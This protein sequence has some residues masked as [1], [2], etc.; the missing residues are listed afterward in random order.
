M[1]CYKFGYMDF[2]T[3][4]AGIVMVKHFLRSFLILVCC[5]TVC[6]SSVSA[7]SNEWKSSSYN[8]NNVRKILLLEPQ[9]SYST[10]S[11]D[12][13]DRFEKYPY[14]QE[15]FVEMLND[16]LKTSV[17]CNVYDLAFVDVQIKG[18]PN[19]PLLEDSASQEFVVLRQQQ[20]PQYVDLV[21]SVEVSDYGWYHEYYAAYN[22]RETVKEKVEY[23]GKTEDGKEY[24]GW[25]EVPKEITVHHPAHYE[26]CDEANVKFCLTDPK[27]NKVVWCYS[28]SRYRD[29]FSWSG[30]RDSTGP[31]SMMNRILDAAFN[32][33]PLS[34]NR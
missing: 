24:S 11:E 18:D 4:E 7:E 34:K 13:K 5:F 9:F 3:M 20:L 32:K 22:S 30:S 29:S 21:L 28:D 2:L 8:F 17:K 19:L 14:G 25:I 26:I 27:T 33:I 10:I 16:R 23:G 15:K 1:V 31:E 6:I 12:S